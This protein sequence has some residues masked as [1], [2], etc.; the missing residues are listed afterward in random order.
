MALKRD[1]RLTHHDKQP[2]TA[3]ALPFWARPRVRF[4]HDTGFGQPL[5]GPASSQ[6]APIAA[7]C[8]RRGRFRSVPAAAG[9]FGA[10]RVE[11]TRRAQWAV[12]IVGQVQ[13]GDVSLVLLHDAQLRSEMAGQAA[14]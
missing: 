9:E 14:G 5:A 6:G 8:T 3:P 4:P 12:G 7:T 11:R 2:G 1:A 13:R 10:Q